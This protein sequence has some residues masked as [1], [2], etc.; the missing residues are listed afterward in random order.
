MR[1]ID[2]ILDRLAARDSRVKADGPCRFEAQ[3]PAH[4]DR[5]ASLSVAEGD[6]YRVLLHCHAGC[7]HDDV[8]SA[9]GIELHELFAVSSNGR[10]SGLAT[11]PR[12]SLAARSS[13]FSIDTA[14]VDRC[15]E[16]LL[17]N[18]GA[19]RRLAELRSWSLTAIERLNIG[20]DGT[21]ITIPIRDREAKLVGLGLYQPNP[22]MRGDG[23]SKMLAAPGTV[24]ELWPAPETIDVGESIWITEGEPDAISLWS[25]GIPAVAIPGAGKRDL[26]WSARF[27][28]RRV[29][30]CLD[31]D[32]QGREAAAWL[33]DQL[34]P[35]AAEV[36]LLNL[37]P[38]R[39]D[40]WDVGA[41]IREA[42]GSGMSGAGVRT[43][44]LRMADGVKPAARPAPVVSELGGGDSEWPPLVAWDRPPFPV[45]AL[46]SA[47]REWVLAVAEDT[48]TP[49]DL[50]ALA[51]IGVLSA[52]AMGPE[53]DCGGWVEPSVAL[54]L[55]VAMG[56]G[57]RKSSVLREA[58][59]PLVHLQAELRKATE[60][61]FLADRARRK[62]LA[63]RIG[64]LTTAASKS[65]RAEADDDA[66]RE[67][68]D[69]QREHD[70]IGEPA[71][72]R[73]FADDATPEALAGLLAAHGKMAVLSAESAFLDNLLGRHDKSGSANLHLV[74]GAY[75][76][77]P[78]IVDRRSRDSE[79]FDRPLLSICLAPQP[80]VLATLVTHAT[81]RSQGLVGRFAYAVPESNAGHRNVDAARIPARA[82][83]AWAQTVRHV[84]S[85]VS[86]D[87]ADRDRAF[88]V[89]DGTS[90]SS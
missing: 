90:V 55:L 50:A 1:P 47:L 30:L 9:L 78:T 19:L 85:A 46:P 5:T 27:A 66:E 88:G 51:A 8:C 53:I 83:E 81:A 61:A 18:A 70:E 58:K 24:R 54:Y 79:E 40:G 74:C 84:W 17:T 49:T 29:V 69:A 37:D 36:R 14:H 11:S 80:H 57:E 33:A 71:R 87:T 3:C 82:S 72:R 64:K 12:R 75:T 56:S 26:S 67:L 42:T 77:D 68:I 6:E 4:D 16:A 23:Q 89:R 7:T 39:E 59:R 28:G 21:R 60:P 15:H 76:A 32:T 25:V 63:E 20:L 2:G 62:V 44:L 35:V 65:G 41:L 48:Q 22:D 73:L 45:E 31:A 38:T 43:M 34:V 10:A 52:A 86:A 13:R